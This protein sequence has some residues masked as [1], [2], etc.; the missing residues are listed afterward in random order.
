MTTDAHRPV[1]LDE[2]AA[3][4]DT[5]RSLYIH[6][7]FC[8]RRCFYCDFA[9]KVAPQGDPEEWLAAI[10]GELRSLEE[11]GA[12]VLDASLDTL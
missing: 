4:G 11:E 10:G 12:F 3:E 5:I 2:P 8:S 6:A 1:R 7:P 9:V